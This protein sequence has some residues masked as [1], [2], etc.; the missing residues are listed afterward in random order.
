ML[1][2]AEALASRPP[3]RSLGERETL[4]QALRPVGAPGSSKAA[5]AAARLLR[6]EAPQPPFTRRPTT[7]AMG[8]A[9]SLST[10]RLL[11]FLI[12]FRA[13]PPPRAAGTA[14]PGRPG[15][16]RSRLLRRAAGERPPARA[17]RGALWAGVRGRARLGPGSRPRGGARLT[18]GRRAR[19]AGA[20]GARVPAPSRPV[21]EGL[22]VQLE[23]K[24]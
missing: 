19:G 21:A 7:P 14:G 2:L 1:P 22:S 20:R 11:T 9:R 24:L 12:R 15:E 4:D 10:G 8:L 5:P 3:D 18:S 6:A 23:P 13:I 17:R 16:A